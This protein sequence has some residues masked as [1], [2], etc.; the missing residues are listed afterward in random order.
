MRASWS[1]RGHDGATPPRR[2]RWRFRTAEWSACPMISGAA[3]PLMRP[4]PFRCP[5]SPGTGHHRCRRGPPARG[6]REAEELLV[7]VFTPKSG[8]CPGCP[9]WPASRGPCRCAGTIITTSKMATRR[10]EHRHAHPRAG[11]ARVTH[12][13]KEGVSR[14]RGTYAAP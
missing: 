3:R 1:P 10:E 11:Q 7:S 9:P 8:S 2:R 12:G 4:I 14:S 6:E 13:V 5:R